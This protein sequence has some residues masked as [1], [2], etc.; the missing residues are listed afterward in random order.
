MDGILLG[1][2]FWHVLLFFATGALGYGLLPCPGGDFTWHVWGGVF[3]AIYTVLCHALVFIYFLGS[4][5][6]IKENCLAHRFPADLHRRS[7]ELKFAAF[8]WAMAGALG[9]IAAT[10]LGGG[11]DTGAVAPWVHGSVACAALG[12]NLAAFALARRAV[13][14]NMDLMHELE[15]YI[16]RLPAGGSD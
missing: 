10:V 11:A 15:V 16:D 12:L 6:Y 5:R 1:L 8:P 9:T 2:A 4:G 14:R 7:R 13:R 3:T